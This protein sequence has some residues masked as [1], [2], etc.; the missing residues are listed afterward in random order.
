M[1]RRAGRSD[2]LGVLQYVLGIA[3]C[4]L[5]SLLC[6]TRVVVSG[7]PALAQL[8]SSRVMHVRASGEGGCAQRERRDRPGSER[9]AVGLPE[10][11]SSSFC[12]PPRCPPLPAL[13][14]E[15]VFPR[16][17]QNAGVDPAGHPALT[18]CFSQTRS[19][20][21]L[22]ET[23]PTKRQRLH[24]ATA[25]TSLSTTP[26]QWTSSTTRALRLPTL[27]TSYS[28]STLSTLMTTG[29]SMR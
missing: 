20:C 14:C 13:F 7:I 19:L 10:V 11:T 25:A 9:R 23:D 27:T 29:G 26:T 12:A 8:G 6:I 28:T 2:G 15:I 24:P 17:W 18:K 21:L 3:C 1:L 22:L 16:T 4:S 5:L